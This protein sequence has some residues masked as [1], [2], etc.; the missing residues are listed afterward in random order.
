MNSLDSKMITWLKSTHHR[1]WVE[2]WK[3]ISLVLVLGNIACIRSECYCPYS[4]WAISLIFVLSGI[5]RDDSELPKLP[6][7]Q[8]EGILPRQIRILVERRRDVKNLMK[9]D[10]LSEHQRQQY[11][12][13]QMALKLTANSMYGCLGFPHCRFYA[14]PLA[15][16]ITSRGREILMHT[17]DLVEKQGYAVIYGDTDSIMIDTGLDDLNQVKKLGFELKRMV[18]KCHKKLEL[19]IDGVYKRLLLLKKKKYAGLAVDLNDETKM[20]RE[21]KGLDIVRR[22]WS[23]L[24]KDI[25]NEIVGMI[26]SLSTGRDE[27]VEHIHERLR[28]VRKELDDGLVDMC[29]FEIM[30][31]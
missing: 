5:T 4:F 9:S 27:L 25:G 14:K 8:N 1:F 12:V 3:V 16:L 28:A 7:D 24:A 31:V 18:N 10:K 30:K 19:D 11:N 23:V 17:K 2:A 20:E 22:D 21:M 13:R 6:D 26:L 29:K 15:A